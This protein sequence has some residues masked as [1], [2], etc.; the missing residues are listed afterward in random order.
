MNHPGRIDGFLISIPPSPGSVGK[1]FCCVASGHHEGLGLWL[2]VSPH[3]LNRSKPE[4]FEA[5]LQRG[6]RGDAGAGKLGA[7]AN[8]TSQ[9]PGGATTWLRDPPRWSGSKLRARNTYRSEIDQGR[10]FLAKACSITAVRAPGGKGR[11]RERP[12]DRIWRS[13]LGP[14]ADP[15]RALQQEGEFGLPFHFFDNVRF[16]RASSRTLTALG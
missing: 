4:A 11:S 7:I 5:G 14:F 6:L 12:L 2:D 10:A 15:A 8:L 9:T 13:G 16:P 3:A 1:R